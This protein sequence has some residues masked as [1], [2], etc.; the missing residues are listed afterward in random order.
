MRGLIV[1][2]GFSALLWSQV[3]EAQGATPDAVWVHPAAGESYRGAVCTKDRIDPVVAQSRYT[4]GRDEMKSGDFMKSLENLHISYEKNCTEHEVLVDLARAYEGVRRFSSAVFALTEYIHRANPPASDRE[5]YLK[6]IEVDK[7][8]QKKED[9]AAVRLAEANAK[10]AA[11]KQ[12]GEGGGHSVAPWAVAG[13]GGAVFATGIVVTAIGYGRSYPANCNIDTGECSA[14]RQP[15]QTPAQAKTQ[16]DE[17]TQTAGNI[18][19]QRLIGP[20]LLVSGAVIAAGGLVWHFMEPI[21]EPESKQS[22]V[23]RPRLSPALAPGYAG[24]SLEGSF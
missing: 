12:S 21:A 16:A 2:A 9:E 18:R 15:L 10:A 5:A 8:E 22:R 14:P 13:V 20:I 4:V 11:A 6:R 23:R 17:D 19:G 3:A 7:L 1:A 24:A